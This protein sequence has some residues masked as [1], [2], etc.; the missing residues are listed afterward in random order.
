MGVYVKLGIGLLALILGLSAGSGL[1]GFLSAVMLL[2][3]GVGFLRYLQE[4]RRAT[5]KA[6]DSQ[7]DEWLNE[8]LRPIAQ[9]GT[10][11]LGV[12][13]TELG[14]AEGDSFRLIF[15]GIPDIDELA[16][17]RARGKDGNWRFSAY[18]IMVV[19]LSTWRLP[20]YE[21]ILDMETG[22]TITDATREYNLN[23]VDG[24][25]TVSDRINVFQQKP[26]GQSTAPST[27]GA[28]GHVTRRQLV[29]LIVSGRE[30]ISLWIGI[31]EGQATQ[32]EGVTTSD[33]D[34][35]IARLREHL[36]AH[37]HGAHQANLG[38]TGAVSEQPAV[39]ADFG[40]DLPPQAPRNVGSIEAVTDDYR[41]Q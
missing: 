9:V 15:V 14:S 30:A 41:Q 11:R 4:L 35:M 6:T 38:L 33:V 10:R 22:A 17:R 36:R 18:K 39:P 13:P 21:C 26:G 40:L 7:M 16:Y 5:P 20:V 3:G 32:L 8:A 28:L 29:K 23:Q 27:S 31:A 19:Y 34:G 24:I 12:H 37:H 1:L 25:D 2:W